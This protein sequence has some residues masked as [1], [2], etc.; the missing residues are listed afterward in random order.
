[1]TVALRCLLC[2]KF[3]YLDAFFFIT[4]FSLFAIPFLLTSLK[5]LTSQNFPSTNF[6]PAFLVY[7]VCLCNV[8]SRMS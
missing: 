6:P 1:M 4:F 5:I 2:T 7:V 3:P 8:Q